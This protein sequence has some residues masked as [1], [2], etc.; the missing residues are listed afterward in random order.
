M[1]PETRK[2]EQVFQSVMYQSSR[3]DHLTFE[4]KTSVLSE[5]RTTQYRHLISKLLKNPKRNLNPA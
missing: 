2:K 4:T 1:F 3:F 5:I